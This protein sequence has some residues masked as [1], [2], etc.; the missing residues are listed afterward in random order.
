MPDPLTRE[1]LFE[2]RNR[3]TRDNPLYWELNSRLCVAPWSFA[4]LNCA[5]KLRREA[6]AA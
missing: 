6:R 1:Q 5:A 3:Y 4:S 2:Q